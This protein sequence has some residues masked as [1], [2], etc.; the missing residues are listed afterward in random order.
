MRSRSLK[1]STALPTEPCSSSFPTI[2]ISFLSPLLK[3]LETFVVFHCAHVVCSFGSFTFI[4]IFKPLQVVQLPYMHSLLSIEQT[5]SFTKLSKLV[6]PIAFILSRHSTREMVFSQVLQR[7]VS[8]SFSDGA[9]IQ[10]GFSLQNVIKLIFS[11][12]SALYFWYQFPIVSLKSLICFLTL[13]RVF[14][15]FSLWWSLSCRHARR[16]S[17]L[18]LS[19]VMK[20]ILFLGP[21]FFSCEP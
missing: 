15:R 14:V 13:Y 10:K 12:F 6:V 1:I 11:R 4:L 18:Y 20:L 7:H 2:F 8:L 3:S 9:L 19:N 16:S 17:E 5:V 21:F